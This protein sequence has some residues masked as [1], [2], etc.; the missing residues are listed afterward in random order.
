MEHFIEKQ[1][2]K[3]EPM[4]S[5]RRQNHLKI[6]LNDKIVGVVRKLFLRWDH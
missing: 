6:I 1:G 3:F 4:C 2:V 5:D